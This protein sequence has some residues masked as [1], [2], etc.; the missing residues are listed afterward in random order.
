MFFSSKLLFEC[1]VIVSVFILISMT[2]DVNDLRVIMKR[3]RQRILVDGY[4]FNRK[5][6]VDSGDVL[7]DILVFFVKV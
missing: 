4:F 5:L 6:L 3:V 7:L 1:K 2:T